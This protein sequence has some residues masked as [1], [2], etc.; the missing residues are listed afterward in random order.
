MAIGKGK[1]TM[2]VV[3][4][5]KRQYEVVFIVGPAQCDD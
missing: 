2:E 1:V 4:E 3:L 5:V